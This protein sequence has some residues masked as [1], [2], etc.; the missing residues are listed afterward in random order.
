M[1]NRTL[2]GGLWFNPHSLE[3]RSSPGA[4]TR[5]LMLYLG[6]KVLR[7]AIEPRHD[8]WL[9]LGQVQGSQHVPYEVSVELSLMP[10]GGVDH[11]DSLC[12]CPVHHQCKH[13]VAL[14]LKAAYKGLQLLGSDAASRFAPAPPTPE[15]AQAARQ[16]AQARVEEKARL[17]AEA[18]LL[19]WLQ[20][21]DLASGAAPQAQ[22][23]DRPEHYL[24][25]L[26]LVNLPG[27]ASRLQLDATLAYRKVNGDWAKP[28][29]IR[30]QPYQGQAVYDAASAADHE[31]LQ[32]LHAMP[33][34][35]RYY[36]AYSAS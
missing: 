6:Q 25:L 4:W 8:D 18:A 35:H 15:E 26:K 36:S 24:Y 23:Q 1:L 11:W 30:T 14:M 34:N 7:L 13:G 29:I 2:N 16:T 33:N 27:R 9:L 22:R 20:A 31:V 3:H 12:T 19:H 17:E 10:D 21:I 5:G 28:K 32:L